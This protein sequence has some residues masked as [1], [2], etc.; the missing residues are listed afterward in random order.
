MDGRPGLVTSDRGTLIV[1]QMDGL[2]GKVLQD[3]VDK[4]ADGPVQS[5]DASN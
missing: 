3:V 2:G 1:C 4:R 5:W